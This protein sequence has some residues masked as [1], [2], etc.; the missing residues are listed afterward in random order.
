MRRA[1]FWIVVLATVL[2]LGASSSWAGRPIVLGTEPDYETGTLLITGDDLGSD[3]PSVRM[4]SPETGVEM[5]L[6]VLDFNPA[7]GLIEV[8]LPTE[9]RDRPG[10]YMMTVE[11]GGP[12]VP[13]RFGFGRQN[14]VSCE[15]ALGMGL[16]G[17]EGPT[18]PKG[19][20][21]PKG[22]IGPTGPQGVQG[23]QGP[24]GNTGPTGGLGPVGPTGPQGDPGPM[25][26]IWTKEENRVWVKD[27]WVSIGTPAPKGPFDVWTPGFNVEGVDQVSDEDGTLFA[28]AS[29]NWQSFLPFEEWSEPPAEGWGLLAAIEVKAPSNV[30]N[31]FMTLSIYSGEGDS[32][33]LLYTQDFQFPDD[34]SEGAHHKIRIEEPLKV[35][36]GTLYTWAIEWESD[37]SLYGHSGEVDCYVHGHS[38]AGGQQDDN[39][40]FW[41]RTYVRVP[42]IWPGFLVQYDEHHGLLEDGPVGIA[43][44]GIGTQ[45]PTTALDVAHGSLRIQESRTPAASEN[46][47]AGE[48]AWDSY[49]LYLCVPVGD[50]IIGWKRVALETFG[51]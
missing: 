13:G 7:L 18:G 31:E 14:S 49:Y 2:C 35:Q 39:D 23:I 37:F 44:A 11:R 9:Y 46:C 15:V 30:S 10:T 38:S 20:A 27:E 40:D 19:D 24:K 47:L 12:V 51:E 17:P 45:M 21:G 25:D 28:P 36:A 1:V 4:F 6:V 50:G 32:G 48:F 26:G 3:W 5:P 42:A 16:E 8:A 34:M 43:M 22:P 33:E 29:T 41:F